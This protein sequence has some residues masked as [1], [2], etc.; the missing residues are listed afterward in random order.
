MERLFNLDGQF[1]F[2]A[3]VLGAS[4][5][6]LF[7]FLSYFLF[8]P[9][10]NLLEKRRERVVAEQEEAKQKKIEA[11]VFKEEY[12]AKLRN[13]DKEVEV[14]LGDARK[15]AQKN[16]AKI[17]AEAKEEAARIIDRARGEIELEKKR[18]V[19]E[20]KQD[21]IAISSLMASKVVS[22]TIDMKVQDGLIE[23]TLKEMG[24]ST[25]QS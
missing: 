25:W 23:E 5:L 15:K 12:E 19:D 6:V 18:A 22:A 24:E 3:A 11:A 14:I 10:R 1:L 20:V 8:E 9:V 7:V 16:E 21:L 4:I 2:D 17:I 13:I